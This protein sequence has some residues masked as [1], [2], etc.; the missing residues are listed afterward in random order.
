MFLIASDD[1]SKELAMFCIENCKNDL[2]F[3]TEQEGRIYLED[4]DFLM[5]FWKENNYYAKPSITYTGTG[6]N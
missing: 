1:L 4:I 2:P 3:F 5:R 6:D